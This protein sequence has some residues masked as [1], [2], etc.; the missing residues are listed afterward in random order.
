MGE[1]I[2]EEIMDDNIP[3]L[4]KNKRRYLPEAPASW[5]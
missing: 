4:M 5:R 1:A 2:S 3:K